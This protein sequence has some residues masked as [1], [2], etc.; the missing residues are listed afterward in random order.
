MN[1]TQQADPF[2]RPQPLLSSRVPYTHPVGGSIGPAWVVVLGAVVGVLG[3]VVL[4]AAAMSWPDNSCSI[5]VVA[6][7]VYPVPMD[8]MA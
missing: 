1:Q 8:W 5:S 4:G 7:A 3:V 6:V 2:A